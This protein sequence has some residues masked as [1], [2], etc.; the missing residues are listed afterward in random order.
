MYY[1]SEFVNMSFEDAIGATREALKHHD[2]EVLAEI[3]LAEVLRMH[4][5]HGSRPYAILA[6]CSPRLARRA[7][8]AE[9][10]IGS[11]VLC[12][13]IVQQRPDGQVEISAADPAATIGAINDVE[14]KWVAREL[15]SMVQQ[16]IE[17]VASRPAPRS[18]LGDREQAGCQLAE[19]LP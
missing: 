8:R 14:L 10:E 19:V 1:F 3:D 11:I 6:T 7:I 18:A 16:V 15:R 17:D 2:F 5:A 9:A 13:F 12:N 4:L